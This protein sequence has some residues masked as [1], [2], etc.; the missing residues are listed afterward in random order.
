MRK[1][2]MIVLV[3]GVLLAQLR[4]ADAKSLKLKMTRFA[5][6]S[7]VFTTL[8]SKELCSC[9]FVD[10]LT[11]SECIA[12][13]NLPSSVHKIV[14]WDVDYEKQ[15]VAARYN[16]AA[17]V[18]LFLFTLPGPSAAARFVTEHPEHGCVV[19]KGP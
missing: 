18:G 8:V 6:S 15:T 14:S 11:E 13:D 2:M 19:T 12:R 1:V 7:G 10:G 4:A 16:A 17:L 3:F 9:L 5:I